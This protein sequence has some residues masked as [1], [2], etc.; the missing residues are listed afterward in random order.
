D[1][2]IEKTCRIYVGSFIGDV[3]KK[4]MEFTNKDT[5]QL[6]KLLRWRR[7]V[8]HFKSDPI[9]EHAINTM[10]ESMALAPSVGNSRP[11]R[12]VRVVSDTMRAQIIDNHQ[13]ANTSAAKLY[14]G[15]QYDHYTKLKLAGLREAPLQLAVFT[16]PDPKEGHGLGRQTMPETLAYSTVAAI[17]QMW[18]AA[19]TMNIGIG[20]VS[21][22]DDKQI[23]RILDVNPEWA[24]TAYLCI[25]YPEDTSDEPELQKEGWQKNENPDWMIR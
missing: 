16:D 4:S 2:G 11:W 22:I 10:Q 6:F 13:A 21:I 18:L 23:N 14:G 24:L 9:P 3:T 20:W 1:S 8:R 12:V 25:G 19:R 15:E 17:H 7:D 5:D